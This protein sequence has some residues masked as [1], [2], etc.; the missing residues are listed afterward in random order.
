MKP[1]T[2][3]FLLAK[4][5]LAE[6]SLREARSLLGGAPS[7]LYATADAAL[8]DAAMYAEAAAR[9][10]AREKAKESQ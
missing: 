8:E 1:D 4:I 2:I 5:S 6:E 10:A 7:R 9:R 3:A